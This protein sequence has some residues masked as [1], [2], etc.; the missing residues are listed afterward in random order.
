MYIEAFCF[1]NGGVLGDSQRVSTLEAYIA[2][3]NFIGRSFGC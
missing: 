3:F 1:K 2:N